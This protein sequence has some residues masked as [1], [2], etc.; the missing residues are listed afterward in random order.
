MRDLAN[1]S[2]CG[3]PKT[4]AFPTLA[5]F[6]ST[7]YEPDQLLWRDAVTTPVYEANIRCGK[8]RD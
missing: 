7:S 1:M 2:V 6:T 8:R 3:S 4:Y 5:S